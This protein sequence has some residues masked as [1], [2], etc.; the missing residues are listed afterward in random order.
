LAGQEKSMTVASFGEQLRDG[1]GGVADKAL[2]F[3][4]ERLSRS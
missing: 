1:G 2:Q 3:V 4:G